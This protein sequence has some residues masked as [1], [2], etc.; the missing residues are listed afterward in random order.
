LIAASGGSSFFLIIIIAFA[1]LWLIVVR[2]Q[3][4]RQTQ[5]QQMLQ[6]LQIGDEVLTAGGIYGTITAIEEDRVT[7]QIA[8]TL[9]VQVARRAIAGVTVEPEPEEDEAPEEPEESAE[10][11]HEDADPTGPIA[12][13]DT[14]DEEKRG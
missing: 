6:E 2:P 7:V 5:Q 11:P 10:E 1:V 13:G 12:G 4:K 14:S 8:P 3:R 9:E